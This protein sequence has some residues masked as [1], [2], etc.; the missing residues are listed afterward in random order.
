MVIYL[1]QEGRGIGLG[2]KVRAYALQAEGLDT[3]EAN[4]RLGFPDDARRYDIAA[5]MLRA[6]GVKSIDLMTNSP[7]KLDGLARHGVQVRRVPSPATLQPHNRGYLQS[8]KDH[9]GHLIEALDGPA[10]AVAEEDGS[11]KAG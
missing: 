8:K 5:A 4:R 7:A 2:N 3:F 6:L 9:T 1:R 10:P 11:V